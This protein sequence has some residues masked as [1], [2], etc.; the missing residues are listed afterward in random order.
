MSKRCLITGGAGF[1]GHHLVEHILTTTDWEVVVLDGLTYAGDVGRIT[2]CEGYDANRVEIFWHDLRSSI[3]P[4]LDHRLGNIDGVLHL[5]ANSH[6]ENSIVDPAPFFM[7]NAAIT[8]NMLE[9]LKWRKLSWNDHPVEH[10]IQISTDEVYGAAPDGYSHKEWDP[11]VPSNP[12]SA[13]KAAQEAAAIAY[14]RTYRLPVVITNTMNIFGERQSPEKFI[15]M[16]VKRLIE[17]ETIK[18][19]GQPISKEEA[20]SLWGT[21]PYCQPWSLTSGWWRAGSRIWLHAR[22]HADALC[23]LLEQPIA[24]HSNGA[25][26]PNRWN[27][28]GQFEVD[29]LTMVKKIAEILKLEPKF[30]MEDF[31]SS[32]PG[33]DLRYSLDGTKLN[34]AGWKPPVGFE[35]ALE[36]TVMWMVQD[37]HSHWLKE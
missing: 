24:T 29:N 16:I 11:I 13:S 34:K 23:W 9:W 32:R 33:H 36:K 14:W 28:A 26:V 27:V 25:T 30:E 35:E 12:Y 8:I 1:A 6:V 22:N 17:G 31:H 21:S 18:V 3:S 7:A 2:D 15:P 19:H 4:T 37:Q 20:Q 10:F 5:A